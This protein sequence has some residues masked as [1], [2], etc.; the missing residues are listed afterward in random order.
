MNDM[1]A[2]MSSLLSHCFGDLV[3][4]DDTPGARHSRRNTLF[5]FPEPESKAS[6]IENLLSSLTLEEKNKVPRLSLPME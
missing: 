4:R 2:P 3:Y 6:E 1:D 5:S